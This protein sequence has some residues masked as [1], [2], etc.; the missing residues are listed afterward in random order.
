MPPASAF[1]APSSCKGEAGRLVT[2]A[3]AAVKLPKPVTSRV[4]PLA[5]LGRGSPETPPWLRERLLPVAPGWVLE[6][7]CGEAPAKGFADAGSEGTA[8]VT[9]ARFAPVPA[10]PATAPDTPAVVVVSQRCRLA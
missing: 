6:R 3:T 8:A 5:P 10:L 1:G 9:A 4:S 2:L 7:V